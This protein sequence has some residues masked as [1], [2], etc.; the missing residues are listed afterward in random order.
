LAVVSEVDTP[1]AEREQRVSGLIQEARMAGAPY[2]AAMC[3]YLASA[4]PLVNGDDSLAQTFGR[5]AA[6]VAESRGWPVLA[7]KARALSPGPSAGSDLEEH[8]TLNEFGTFAAPRRAQ[9][10]AQSDLEIPL[11]DPFDE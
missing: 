11:P 5:W 3:A 2:L 8:A 10:P 1:T 6:E 9:S 7:S 4:Y